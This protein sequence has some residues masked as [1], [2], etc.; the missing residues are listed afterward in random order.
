MVLW[1]TSEYKV[2]LFDTDSDPDPDFYRETAMLRNLRKWTI[3][4]SAVLMIALIALFF[5][6]E[7][8]IGLGVRQFSQIAQCRFQSDRIAALIAMVDCDSCAMSDRNHAVWALGQLA[9]SRALPILEKQ[10]TGGKCDHLHDICQYELEKAL[11]LVR[12]GHNVESL[13]WR[14]MLD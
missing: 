4:I 9:D 7:I 3:R 14:W 5:C 2:R 11:R 1:L 12:N 8:S 10:Y 13:F 6:A